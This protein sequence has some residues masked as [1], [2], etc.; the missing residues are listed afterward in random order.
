MSSALPGS[1]LSVRQ[2]NKGWPAQILVETN[3]D[4]LYCLTG[5]VL[6]IFR[7]PRRTLHCVR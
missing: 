4:R 1:G 5:H 6:S 7:Y 2:I 3:F